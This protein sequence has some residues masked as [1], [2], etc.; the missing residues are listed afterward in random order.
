M[1]ARKSLRV[2]YQVAEKS[3]IIDPATAEHIELMTSLG[4]SKSKLSLFGVLNHCN[5]QGGVRLLR[6]NLFQPPIDQKVIMDRLQVVEE[7]IDNMSLHH[8]LKS[9]ISKF[10]DLDPVLTLCV[11][12]SE[13]DI[14]SDQ[15]DS[16]I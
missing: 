4:Q 6:S 11:K 10:P 3:T 1:F 13:L 16:K 5:T 14:S 2:D 8:N 7:L 9:L 12:R 15:I